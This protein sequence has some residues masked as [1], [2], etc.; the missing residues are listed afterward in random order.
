MLAVPMLK[1]DELI[2]AIG[3]YRQEVLPFTD[4]QIELVTEFRRPGRH[5]DREHA[6]A[7]R[8]ARVAGAADRNF[9]SAARHQRIARRF[10]AGVPTMLE[11]AARICEAKFGTMLSGTKAINSARPQCT[12]AA[13]SGPRGAPAKRYF[14]PDKQQH[15]SRRALARGSTVM[16][17]TCGSI[18]LHRGGPGSRR[19]GG[20]RRRRGRSSVVPMLKD[21][22]VVGVIG[23]YRE[24]VRPFT[25]KQIA[26]VTELCRA[27]RHRHREH[28]AAERI[29]AIAA[30]ADGHGRRA[31]DYQPV[32][33]RSAK[34]CST[35]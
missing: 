27:G 28:A 13:G 4:K 32:H 29:A 18:K 21:E 8:I 24:E 5:R 17:R 22:V 2:G 25:D 31:Q 16:F 20:N 35:R 1:E 3:I 12:C 34:R 6:A 7:L 23:I 10:A 9:R 14:P 19:V 26:L 15:R 11:N 30:A 33:F